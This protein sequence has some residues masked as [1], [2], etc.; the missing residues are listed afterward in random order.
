MNDPSHPANAET[1]DASF[2]PGG[3]AIPFEEEEF[4]FPLSPAQMRIWE[5]DRAFPGNS[6]YNGSFRWELTGSV[7]FRTLERAFN[8]IIRRHEIL[9]ATFREVDGSPVQIIAPSMRLK[10]AFRDLR[11]VA[12]SHRQDEM[13]RLCSEEARRCFDLENGPLLRV[14]LLQMDDDRSI[15]MFTVHH[16]VSDGWS[17]GLIM[18]EL[19]KIYAAFAEDRESPL[20]DL[21]I[22][23]LDYVVWQRDA[24]EQPEA[25]RQFEYWKRK[26]SG[27]E[28]L[29]VA[30]DFERPLERTT[31][32]AI[33]SE[34]LPRELS[35]SLKQFSDRHQG[36]L[37]I[38]GLAA[39]M[40]L[41]ARYTG[42]DDIAV[43]SPLAG[44]NRTELEVLVGMFVNHV[45]LR[46]S[47]AGDPT[48]PELVS[49]VRETVWE[50]FA[51]Q[52]VPFEN[53]LNS[54]ADD[55][56]QPP[57]PFYA[58][59]FICQR[60]YARASTFV[61]DFAGIRMRT[62]PSKSQGALYD[63][64]FFMVEREMGW[65]LSLEYNVDL[66]GEK[67]ALGMLQDFRGLL[68]AIASNPNR[69]LSEFP[70][71]AA[72]ARR[73]ISTP[74]AESASM[75][76]PAEISS[77]ATPAHEVYAMPASM[78]QK[79]FWL[80]DRLFSGNSAFQL[81]ACV[82][83]SGPVSA[84]LL[85]QSFQRIVD[86]HEILRTTFE[87]IDGELAQ[88][89]APSSA[90]SLA[91]TSL[92]NLP[93]EQRE[94]RVQQLIREEA[95]QPFDLARAPAF[96]A[97]LFRLSPEQHV[98]AI[99]AHH[100]LADG[101]SHGVL[102][103]ELWST[104][105]ALLED[106]EP[107]LAPLPIQFGDFVAWQ[108]EWLASDEARAHLDFWM[109]RLALPLPVPELSVDRHSDK[110]LSPHGAIETLLLPADL[111]A[112]LKAATQAE[113]ATMFALLLTSFVA[114]LAHSTAQDDVV[115]GSPVAN[116]RAETEPLIGPFAGPIALRVDLSGN[117]TLREALHR[118]R[119]ITLDALAHSDLPFESIL[120]KLTPRSVHGH[121]PLFQFYFYYQSAFLQPRN[122]PGLNVAPLPTFSTGT[123]F[124]IQVGVIER[125][126][127]IRIQLEYNPDLFSQARIQRFLSDYHTVLRL[128]AQD[129]ARRISELPVAA[130]SAAEPVPADSK[131]SEFVPPRDAVEC[132]LARIWADV[133]GR[134]K[135]GIRD[136]FFDLGG[137]S[138]LAARLLK[139][140]QNQLGK[141]LALASLLDASTIERQALLIRS[142]AGTL[143]INESGEASSGIPFFYLGAY[144]TF[145]RLTQRLAR[146]CEFHSLGM[147][148]SICRELGPSPRLEPIAA[149]FV[150]AIRERRPHG[151][152]MLGGWC[153][154]G[155]LALEIAQQLRAQGE[156][157]A[158][159]VMIEGANPT[160]R[161]A[162]PK[163][164]RF[165][166]AVQLKFSL[167]RFES[168]Y[169][170]HI[171]RSE[172]LAYVRDRIRTKIANLAGFFTRTGP[173]KQGPVPILYKAVDNY[174]PRPYL[175][176]VLLMR[177]RSKS[178]GFAEDPRLGWGHLLT[179]L[180]VAEV[181]GSHFSIMGADS[182]G[183][184]R[185]ITQH[186]TELEQRFSRSGSGS[187][188]ILSDNPAPGA[189]R[190]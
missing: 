112:S 186:V 24:M 78:A 90:F 89:V 68:D 185:E 154:H 7:E 101:W 105:E 173:K 133:L 52:D 56:C 39:C 110:Q 152:Y 55:G 181:H 18:E 58:V 50:A 23:Y 126:E 99:T 63:L 157:V 43:G 41:L 189:Q 29:E 156:D 131:Q 84:N 77:N 94:S 21:R 137:H 171:K 28:R 65:R 170:R 25:F 32:S 31:T 19:Q 162:Y 20:P 109:K 12:P 48:F 187:H 158:L 179:D 145:R 75:S 95:Q 168:F 163:W 177:G 169:L 107:Q 85:E 121:N 13:D 80:L 49:R 14:G 71:P 182:E 129:P 175:G 108:K 76:D 135:I 69:K 130:P 134:D 147:Q 127:G 125:Q 54:L 8:E 172:G 148:E 103:N 97:R 176:R 132:E 51:N 53:V 88:I 82:R 81:P 161:A 139:R 73:G 149:Q 188:Q 106:R 117:P 26:L 46:A 143:A 151:P 34:L 123:S 166:S 79:R 47:A 27:Y 64:N 118:V 159:V 44:R 128:L 5:A 146:A 42:K 136:D 190:A 138:L 62:M 33:V 153:S 141:E 9:R 38:T 115:I 150:R 6:A 120:E 67:T 16:I 72:D 184:A 70:F 59:N 30:T 165:I 4:A 100:I 17:I 11:Y 86:R 91:I 124:E 114:L 10:V 40:A 104:Y 167:F 183:L 96:R 155:V 119:D 111:T 3:L 113:S 144:P 83:L 142:G 87:E 174:E 160:A 92:E 98:L 74:L 93:E 180:T 116:R 66:Y 15:L 22:Q 37:F 45:V 178:F 164:K 61:F 102:Q 57:S 1:G 35:D 122:L 36:T 140:I 60:E 2:I